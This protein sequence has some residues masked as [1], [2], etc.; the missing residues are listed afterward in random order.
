MPYLQ[1]LLLVFELVKLAEELYP[2]SGKG[3]EKL[4]LVRAFLERTIPNLETIW[5]KIQ[6]AIEIFVS[7]ANA[8]GFF[9]K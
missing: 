4:T 7:L 2:E 8:S 6:R 3:A 5:P 1:I 9:K